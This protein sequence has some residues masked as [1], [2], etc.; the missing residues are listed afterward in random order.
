M[1]EGHGE[2]DLEVAEGGRRVGGREGGVGVRD[3]EEGEGLLDDEAVMARDLSCDDG[4]VCMVMY[5][6]TLNARNVSARH[7]GCNFGGGVTDFFESRFDPTTGGTGEALLLLVSEAQSA[8]RSLVVLEVEH[9]IVGPFEGEAKVRRERGKVDGGVVAGGMTGMVLLNEVA[10]GS[11]ALDE[12]GADLIVA[13]GREEVLEEKGAG[14]VVGEFGLT[15]ADLTSGGKGALVRLAERLRVG[16]FP[17]ARARR[18]L[19]KPVLLGQLFDLHV[20]L[21][22]TQLLQLALPRLLDRLL[23][24]KVLIVS[25]LVVEEGED[26]DVLIE[27]ERL[28]WLD[29]HRARREEENVRGV[30]RSR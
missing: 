9:S 1:L 4:R 29:L 5:H 25:D 21:S 10:D 28:V 18:R 3:G 17:V 15:V 2:S 23:V 24:L 16:T 14:L 26:D 8:V 6:A 19:K 22:A 11:N 30:K 27:R 7:E 12:E 13:V 20:D